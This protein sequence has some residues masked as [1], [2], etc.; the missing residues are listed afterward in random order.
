ME[1]E[2]RLINPRWSIYD[3]LAVLATVYLIKWLATLSPINGWLTQFGTLICPDSPT[4]GR[5]FTTSI[6]I[7]GVVYLVIGLL[8]KKRYHLS[9]SEVG[10]SKGKGETWLMVITSIAETFLLF[11][12]I[13]ALDIIVMYFLS[14]KAKPQATTE[15]VNTVYTWWGW[16]LSFVH[17]VVVAPLSEELFFR[18]FLFPAIGKL[19]GKMIPA[20]IL[21]SVI[22]GLFHCDLV[23]FLPLTVGAFWF[24]YL[25]I[26]TGSIYSSM[27]AHGV[28]NF[29]MLVMVFVFG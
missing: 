9:W 25:Y 2:K 26:R 20:A 18:G 24:N 11:V 3:A 13:M 19:V 6:I 7:L 17:L 27:I 28:W 14:I 8:L 10:F 15:I 21:T 12:L 22:F 5:N 23:R 4:L 1:L 16:I 29:L